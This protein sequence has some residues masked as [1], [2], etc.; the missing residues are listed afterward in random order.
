MSRMCFNC[1]KVTE[2]GPFCYYCGKKAKTPAPHHLTPGTVLHGKYT[3][4]YALGEGGFGITYAGLDNS[5]E[6]KVAIKEFFPKG[7]VERNSSVS[8]DVNCMGAEENAAAFNAEKSKVINEARILAKF[9]KEHGIVNVREYFEE[10][11][12]AYIVMEYLEGE[13]L[14]Q[15]VQKNGALSPDRAFELLY[16]VMQVV[17][18]LHKENV[19]HRDISPDNIMF[20]GNQLK[21]LDFGAA[22]DVL[23]STNKSFS[24]ILKHGYAPEEQYRR[25]GRQG[26]WTDVYALCATMY[27]CI[28]KEI[29]DTALDRLHEDELRIPSQLG[30][31]ITP[32]QE[33]ALM[34]G[35][36]VLPEDRLQSIADFIAVWN[37]KEVPFANKNSETVVVNEELQNN[38]S[39]ESQKPQSVSEK[40]IEQKTTPIHR[41]PPAPDNGKQQKKKRKSTKTIIVVSVVV[42]LALIALIVG[43]A[44]IFNR[45]DNESND[46][47]PS[48]SDEFNSSETSKPAKPDDTVSSQTFSQDTESS[49]EPET[50]EPDITEDKIQEY[51]DRAYEMSEQGNYIEAFASLDTAKQLYGSSAKIDDARYN[52][53]KKQLLENVNASI[54]VESY[55]EAIKTINSSSASLKND[56]EIVEKYNLCVISY[57]R[58]LFANAENAF[59]S[60]GYN[61]AVSVLQAGLDI[62]PNDPD[63]TEKI[64]SYKEHEP[65]SIYTLLMRGYTSHEMRKDSHGDDHSDSLIIDEYVEFETK[66]EYK[67]L[68]FKASPCEYFSTYS[69]CGSYVKVYADDKLVY[70]SDLITYKTYEFEVNADISGANY[71]RITVEEK[72]WNRTEDVLVYDAFVSK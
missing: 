51:I 64:S 57:K 47:N 13:T 54:E 10:N 5:L 11:N 19:V 3:V 69:S 62:L 26:S 7:I 9:S 46:S 55:V 2:D 38:G 48:Y 67:K 24:V 25:K 56:R 32:A 63:I 44:I 18:Q 17:E 40:P 60:S 31:Q 59:N 72:T 71:V 33:N 1:M 14:E 23:Y 6:M 58:Q 39:S 15:Y 52:I 29:P 27:Y 21:L 43:A 34:R 30:I 68:S 35:L 36:G 12:T 4:G 61:D 50:S 70:T 65:V 16:P 8:L 45:S 66:G 53:Q 37:G 20:D 22:R 42:L 28:T 41:A 49:S